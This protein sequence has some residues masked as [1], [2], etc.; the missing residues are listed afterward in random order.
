[1]TD[2]II[3]V[4]IGVICINDK[5]QFLFG[6]RK[7]AHGEGT[8]A[9]PGGHLEYNESFEDGA[10]REVLE[11]TGLMLRRFKI[12]TVANHLFPVE[13]KH[14]VT[15]N[16]IGLVDGDPVIKEPDKIECWSFYDSWNDLPQ[17]QFVPMDKD[18]PYKSIKAYISENF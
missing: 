2:K 5:K 1:M 3:R 11:E 9:P 10:K 4:G 8:W 12:L 17:P 6:K 16:C 7:N 14:Y 13:G 18:V 15:I